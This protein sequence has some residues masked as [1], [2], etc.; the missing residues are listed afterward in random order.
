M[1]EKTYSPWE[2]LAMV[3]AFV[4]MGFLFR[5]NS[6]FVNNNKYIQDDF[7][8]DNLKAYIFG[9]LTIVCWGFANASL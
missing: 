9:I 8:F 2:L 3:L 1:I 4:G 5:G 6:N 7:E